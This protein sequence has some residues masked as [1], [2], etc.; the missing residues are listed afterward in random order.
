MSQ[1]KLASNTEIFARRGAHGLGLIYLWPWLSKLVAAT[2][3][4]VLIPAT[5]FLAWLTMPY[6]VGLPPLIWLARSNP[7]FYATQSEGVDTELAPGRYLMEKEA[8]YL[9]DPRAGGIINPDDEALRPQFG[10]APS[11]V[12]P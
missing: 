12:E 8:D 2:P 4:L 11:T 7:G 9:T 3:L 5:L 1:I 6:G 10:R